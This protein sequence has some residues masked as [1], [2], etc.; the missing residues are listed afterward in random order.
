MNRTQTATW[1]NK[2]L[3]LTVKL[4]SNPNNVWVLN[5]LTSYPDGR[6]M[7][8]DPTNVNSGDVSHFTDPD[9]AQAAYEARKTK[10][11]AQFRSAPDEEFEK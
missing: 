8:V 9:K 1:K 3:S 4:E 11:A 2:Y 10:F 5:T 7:L 6:L